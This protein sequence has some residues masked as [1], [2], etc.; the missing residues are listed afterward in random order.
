MQETGNIGAGVL[1]G[2]LLSIP[3][4]MAMIGWL[5]ILSSL[6]ISR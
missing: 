4:W 5:Q 3:L 6:W 2:I 1:W